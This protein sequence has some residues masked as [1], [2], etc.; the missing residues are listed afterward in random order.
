MS[1]SFIAATIP[2][3]PTLQLGA[4]GAQV[5]ELQKLVNTH[6]SIHQQIAE[7]GIFEAKTEKAIRLIQYRFFLAQDGIVGAKT[8]QVLQT[9]KLVEKPTLS[10]GSFGKLVGK[11]QQ[12]LKDGGLYQGGV[13]EEFGARTK[14]AVKALQADC[15]LPVDGVIGNDT[16]QALVELARV[17]TAL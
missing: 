8:W 5:K 1:K 13:D 9:R 10:V 16:W 4:Q 11:V 17:L 3:L 7:D 12:V 15:Q 14:I 6:L 2:S